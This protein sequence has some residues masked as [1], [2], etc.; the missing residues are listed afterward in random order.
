[1][2]PQKRNYKPLIPITYSDYRKIRSEKTSWLLTK[3]L[4]HDR[5]NSSRNPCFKSAHTLDRLSYA[6]LF[7][8]GKFSC[9]FN[10]PCQG[11]VTVH[12][13]ITI[14]LLNDEQLDLHQ[15]LLA[16]WVLGYLLNLSMSLLGTNCVTTTTV[17][18]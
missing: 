14:V 15:S 5:Q 10:Q 13:F 4:Y 17:L 1:M 16:Q 18:E 2:V 11:L 9:V 6:F 8:M 12:L 7:P 3:F